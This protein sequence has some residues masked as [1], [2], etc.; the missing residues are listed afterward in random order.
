MEDQALRHESR[1]R[2]GDGEL[3]H[4]RVAVDVDVLGHAGVPGLSWRKVQSAGGRTVL[5]CHLSLYETFGR[6]CF[7]FFINP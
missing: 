1:Q 3:A 2:V 6:Q 5:F 4:A 7:D